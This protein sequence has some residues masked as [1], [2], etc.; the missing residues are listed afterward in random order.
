MIRKPLILLALASM[1]ACGSTTP[2]P[3]SSTPDAKASTTTT[4][5]SEPKSGSDAAPTMTLHRAELHRIV[6]SGLG[7]FLSRVSLDDHPAKT[8]DG[9]F[10]GFRIA[11]LQG[12]S[13]KGVDLKP[14]DIVTKVNGFPIEHPEQA[15]EVFQSLDVASE[16][17]VGVE[18]DGVP[19]ELRYAIVDP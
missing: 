2:A 7:A 16:L 8:P 4:A 19:R 6:A 13:W 10:I 14:G 18:R 15:L 17:R 9:K 1:L 5:S 12:N 3:K 11:A